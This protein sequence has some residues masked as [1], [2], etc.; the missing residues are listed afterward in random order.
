MTLSSP[1]LSGSLPARVTNHSLSRWARRFASVFTATV[2]I[3]VTTATPVHAHDEDAA[4]SAFVRPKFQPLRFNEDWSGLAQHYRNATGDFFDPIKYVPLTQDGAIWASFGG[5]ARVRMEAWNN[6]NFGAPAG[7]DHDDVFTLF[8]LR[9]HGDLHVG[10]HLRF[11]VEGKSAL[12]TD[13][14]LVGGRRTS[15]VDSVDLQNAFVD[16]M[17]PLADHRLTLR[18]GRQELLFGSQRLVS[19]LDWANTRRT[20]DGVSAILTVHDWTI[21]G[22]WTQLVEIDKYGFNE[23]DSQN[24]LYGVFASGKVL[25]TSVGLD[26]Y[27]FGLDRDDAA[28][29]AGVMGREDRHT[30]GGRVH[31]ACGESGFDYELEGAYQFGEVG[32]TDISAFMIA[33]QLGYRVTQCAWSPRIFIGFD[34]ASGGASSDE[35]NTFN[36]LFPLGHAY[37]GYIDT[38]G[39]Q[40]VMD[41]N[42]GLT[43]QP[44]ERMTVEL[45]GHVFW[46]AD[47]GDAVYNA[48]GGIVRAGTL[49]NDRHIG[50]EIDLLVKYQFDRHLELQVGYSHF[51]TGAFIENS[52]PSKDIDF[53]YTALQFTF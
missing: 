38:I 19:P 11:F 18:A 26:L 23:G 17:V 22:F 9:L 12:S 45:T 53:V 20:F 27:W 29:Y 48:G 15:D 24:Q 21:T 51:F 4:A 32:D 43:F 13:R 7:V 8:R 6:F 31:G 16:V 44:L 39:R 1:C 47:R 25:D 28:T 42:A 37:L 36:Q 33:T 10:E 30:V 34:Y 2:A 35:V 14:D 41:L 50:S 52:G 5:Q 46:R 3:S 49:A 40:N